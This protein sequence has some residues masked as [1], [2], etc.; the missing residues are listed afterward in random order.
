MTLNK[1]DFQILYNIHTKKVSFENLIKFL[2][3]REVMDSILSL[4]QKGY[5]RI[6]YSDQHIT[7]FFSTSEGALMLNNHY[8]HWKPE[9]G[10]E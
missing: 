7:G 1:K 3:K 10:Y 2:G 4:Q 8:S 5:I 6:S 9:F